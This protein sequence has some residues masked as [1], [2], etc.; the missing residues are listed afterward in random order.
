[1]IL[2]RQL[3]SCSIIPFSETEDSDCHV[4]KL[5]NSSKIR[6]TGTS[7]PPGNRIVNSFIVTLKDGLENQAVARMCS[8]TRFPRGFCFETFSESYVFKPAHVYDWPKLI[9][10]FCRVETIAIV[11]S[12]ADVKT[13]SETFSDNVDFL[14]IDQLTVIEDE[15]L[16]WGI[17]RLD[18]RS[19]PLDNV[20]SSPFDGSG[21]DVYVLDTGIL[22]SH[23]EFGGRALFGYSVFANVWLFSNLYC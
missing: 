6:L 3:G 4:C 20:Y 9:V 21:V 22:P 15:K 1:M 12:P 10:C 16:P 17:N 13:F 23:H 14:E 19:L 11:L 5:L 18:Q 7:T 8:D 2:E